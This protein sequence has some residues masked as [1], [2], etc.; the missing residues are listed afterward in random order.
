MGKALVRGCGLGG[1][2]SGCKFSKTQCLLEAEL[3]RLPEKG[4]QC[5]P[6]LGHVEG[7]EGP[8]IKV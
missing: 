8:R 3:P 2:N 7:S 5:R 4:E 6:E 1:G